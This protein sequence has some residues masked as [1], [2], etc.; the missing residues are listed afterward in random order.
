MQRVL[1]AVQMREAEAAAQ[2]RHGMPSGLLME[3]AGRALADAARSVAGPGGRFTVLCGPGNNG[4]DG[5]VAARFLLEGGARVVVSL[6]GDAAKLTAESK[7]NLQAL[8]GFG[9]SPRAFEAL[10][11]AGAGDVVVDALFGTGLRRAPEGAFA[12]AIGTVARWRRAGARVVAADVP[13]G[14]QSDTAEPFALCVEADVTVAFGFLKPAHEL[15]PGASLCGDVRRVDIGLGGESARAVSGAELLRVEEEDAREVIPARRADTHKGTYGH[16]LVV[17]GSPG[18]TG[19]AAMV[20]LSALRSG[21]GLVTVAARAEALPWVMAHS[22]EIMGIALPGDGPLG[23]GDLEALQAALEGKDA[24]VMGPGIPRGPETGALIGDLLATVDVPAVL[25]ADALNAVAEDLTVLRRAKGPVLLTPHPGEMARLW[26]RTTKDVQQ[27]RVGVALNLATSLNVTVVL[28]G[29]RTLIAEPGGRVFINPTGNA[30][31][32]TGGTGDVLSGVCGALLAQ[33]IKLPRAAWTA[34][35][36]HGL[37]GDLA[38]KRRGL[39]G[40]IATDLLEDLGSV[41]LRW[42]R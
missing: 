29:S 36:A 3:N 32:A 1:T 25:D 23:K 42:G 6:V 35:Y 38:A 15:E 41:W 4:G 16:V 40:L 8:E 21:V 10:P 31:M 33:G 19:A 9:E 24:L 22:P 12:D 18:K 28:K 13:S 7:R 37:A 5:L 2:E 34:V 26:G 11:E 14:L 30:G 20:A 17:A 27:H 39:M